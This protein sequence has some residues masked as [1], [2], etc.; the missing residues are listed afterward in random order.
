MV[1]QWAES[2]IGL[3]TAVASGRRAVQSIC[4]LDGKRFRTTTLSEYSSVQRED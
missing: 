2:T 3:P 4:R 1:G